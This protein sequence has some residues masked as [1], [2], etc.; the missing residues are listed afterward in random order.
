MATAAPIAR[1]PARPYHGDHEHDHRDHP[2]R[3]QQQACESAAVIAATNPT[4]CADE[5][6]RAYRAQRHP[7]DDQ[8]GRDRQLVGDG[9]LVAEQHR[10]QRDR[11]RCRPSA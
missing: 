1:Q 7:R 2:H 5:H 11:R 6:I 3:V 10:I 9:V 4:R 8:Q